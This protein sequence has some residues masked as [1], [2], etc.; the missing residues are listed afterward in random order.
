MVGGQIARY[1]V[2]NPGASR[3]TVG[4]TGYILEPRIV[5]SAAAKGIPIPG[6]PA[7]IYG[8]VPNGSA[9]LANTPPGGNFT[10]N[11]VFNPG[12]EEHEHYLNL[13][14]YTDW[15]GGKLQT[16]M[17]VSFD[18]AT[19]QNTGATSV[20][21]VPWKTYAGYKLGA[22]YQLLP[23]L[24]FYAT[25]GTAATPAGSTSDLDGQPLAAPN[26]K[27]PVPELG[28]KAH[29]ADQRYS[30]QLAWNVATADRNEIQSVDGSYL[31][32]VNPNG[33][34]GRLGGLAANDFVNI[35]HTA[36]SLEFVGT[37][38]PSPNWRL[39]LSLHYLF[40]QVLDAV[41]YRQL[42][43]DQFSVNGAGQVT[44]ADGQ[45]LYVDGTA[46]TAGVAAIVAP[47]TAGATP[48]TLATLNNPAATNP[49]YASPDA[50]SGSITN[51]ALKTILTTG[52][53]AGS[54]GLAQVQA[55]GA[56]ATGVAGLPLSAIQYPVRL[57][58]SEQHGSDLCRRQP[59]DRLSRLAVE[60]RNRLHLLARAA[61]RIR[62]LS[63][64]L[65]PVQHSGLL[66]LLPRQ[67]TRGFRRGQRIPS[68]HR[69]SDDRELQTR[70]ALHRPFQTRP[71]H[72]PDPGEQCL[73]PRSLLSPA[74]GRQRHVPS[75]D[76]ARAAP[77]L[78]VDDHGGILSGRLRE[79]SARPGSARPHD[80]ARSQ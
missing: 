30:A 37:A 23:G 16:L 57:H 66:H 48:L 42:Y 47:S 13:A 51:A 15:F 72:H 33:L 12:P 31:N 6:D 9:N 55:H 26:A 44:Y 28:L 49:Y 50:T 24:G 38:N 27:A 32:A 34:N 56:A 74:P 80:A 8:L 40:A 68:A 41:N 3:V 29:T 65:R 18:R 17:G 53:A 46:T 73:Q 36:T 11:G 5:Q 63:R 43:N 79:P 19:T 35:D 59:D 58:L 61:P 22:I 25:L 14:N 70:P 21:I 60:R 64:R 77:P 1:P 10:F 52:G 39:R 45:V 78:D 20:I 67:R 75:G 2:F 71:V 76:A 69:P 62:R 7:N 54:V 4:G